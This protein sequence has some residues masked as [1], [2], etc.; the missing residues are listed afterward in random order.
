MTEP[1]NPES[2]RS[3]PQLKRLEKHIKVAVRK[4]WPRRRVVNYA[5]VVFDPQTG[6]IGISVDGGLADLETALL[7]AIEQ[8]R[9]HR[10]PE[11]KI[12]ALGR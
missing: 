8:I 10:L 4:V 7:A 5:M 3:H 6:E 12:I 11:R 2:L 1:I 9:R